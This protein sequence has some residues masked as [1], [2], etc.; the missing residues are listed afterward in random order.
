M[1]FLPAFATCC[2]AHALRKAH[3]HYFMIDE[4]S[5]AA[6]LEDSR[7]FSGATMAEKR[8]CIRAVRSSR[9]VACFSGYYCNY[10]YI[11]HHHT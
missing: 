2:L 10:Y 5:A 8:I 1:Y 3:A 11:L 6:D 4:L 9:I 7:T